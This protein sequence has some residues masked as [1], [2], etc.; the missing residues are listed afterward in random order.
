MAGWRLKNERHRTNNKVG[1]ITC[2]LK[3]EESRH[4]EAK[5]F[6]QGCISKCTDL[7]Q[8]PILV[9]EAVWDMSQEELSSSS[10]AP[11][12]TEQTWLSS[13]YK[14]WTTRRNEAAWGHL[15]RS[16]PRGP[17]QCAVA[18]MQALLTPE[19]WSEANPW[20]CD[21][22]CTFSRSKAHI[23]RK[24]QRN[25]FLILYLKIKSHPECVW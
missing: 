4:G 17:R 23:W 7:K 18:A 14:A 10:K 11:L 15:N 21:N 9:L 2:I 3:V 5:W 1:I 19:H 12:S 25:L 22:C 8:A 20:P 16:D 6:S 24:K 13:V